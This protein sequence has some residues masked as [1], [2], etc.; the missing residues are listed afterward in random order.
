MDPH[1]GRAPTTWPR[2]RGEI[3][4]VPAMVRTAAVDR[5]GNLWIS[6]A[7]P[8][9]YVCDAS[10]DKRRTL[11]FRGAGIISPTSFFLPTSAALS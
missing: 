1:V 2:K 11:Q 4:I 7:A 5:E 9:T 10:G 6:L 8:F 3:P